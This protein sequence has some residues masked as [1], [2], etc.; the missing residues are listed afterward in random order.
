MSN[1]IHEGEQWRFTVRPGRAQRVYL[2]LD[3]NT[4]P[5]RWIE[6]QPV[7]GEEGQWDAIAHLFE[8]SYRFRYFIANDGAYLNCGT[9]GLVGERLSAADPAV[10]I[11]RYSRAAVPA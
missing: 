11:E 1:E 9:S 4:I 7:V 3:G 10:R 5:S 6:M 2:V 8:G